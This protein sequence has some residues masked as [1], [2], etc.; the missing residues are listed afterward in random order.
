MSI[1]R[2]LDQIRA[3]FDQQTAREVV[4]AFRA[5]P[6]AWQ[7]FDK[8]PELETWLSFASDDL[9]RWQPGVLAL[10]SVDPNLPEQDLTDLQFELPTAI[11]ER[12]ESVCKVARL[13]GLEP[14]SLADAA[15]L[16]LHLR[17]FRRAEGSWKR[18]AEELLSGKSRLPLWKSAFVVLPQLVPDFEDAIDSLVASFGSAEAETLGSFIVHQVRVSP[19]DENTRYQSYRRWLRKASVSLQISTLR[20]MRNFEDESPLSSSPTVSW[21]SLNRKAPNQAVMPRMPTLKATANRRSSA[22]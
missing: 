14:A 6:L 21:R 18:L 8:S 19:A 7:F 2:L 13:T 11:S 15:L 12:V 1:E 16:A 22:K 4:S 9:S 3:R 5:E 10:F 17:E 20:A